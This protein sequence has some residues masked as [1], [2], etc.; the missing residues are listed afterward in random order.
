MAQ[1]SAVGTLV[2]K[3]PHNL[4]DGLHVKRRLFDSED[5]VT[6]QEQQN[7]IFPVSLPLSLRVSLTLRVSGPGLADLH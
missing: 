7:K 5:A 2:T 1:I 3:Q 4:K 6:G